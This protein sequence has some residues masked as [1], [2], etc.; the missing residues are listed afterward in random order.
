MRKKRGRV[1]VFGIGLI[2]LAFL[3][4][5]RLGRHG[6]QLDLNPVLKDAKLLGSTKGSGTISRLD[7]YQTARPLSDLKAV[8]KAGGWKPTTRRYG[9]EY[10]LS[11]P[12]P[13]FSEVSVVLIDAGE[14]RTIEVRWRSVPL[15]LAERSTLAEAIASP[16][17]LPKVDRD[18]L[19]KQLALAHILDKLNTIR[20]SIVSDN[21]LS[22][23]S[24]RYLVSTIEHG[25]YDSIAHACDDLELAVNKRL[26]SKKKLLALIERQSGKPD[27]PLIFFMDYCS[28]MKVEAPVD[29][30]LNAELQDILSRNKSRTNFDAVEKRF[31]LKALSN[32]FQSNRILAGYIFYE[33]QALPADTYAWMSRLIELEIDKSEGEGQLLWE[34]IARTAEARNNL[35]T[36]IGP[37]ALPTP[38]GPNR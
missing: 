2:L 4:I 21:E 24:A 34:Y 32:P 17:Q 5:S 15:S 10:V 14:S 29:G 12:P 19:A 22:K 38:E 6:E 27:A 8:L 13:Q 16:N 28:L 20:D 23:S 18:E 9:L 1:V 37:N 7:A 3:L 26:Y 30:R 11:S 35:Q 33:K 36:T 31:V 25:E